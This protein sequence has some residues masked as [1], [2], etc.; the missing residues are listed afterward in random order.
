MGGSQEIKKL[1][2]ET[3]KSWQKLCHIGLYKLHNDLDFILRK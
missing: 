1:G 3:N 2:M